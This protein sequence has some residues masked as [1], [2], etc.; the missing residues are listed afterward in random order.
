MIYLTVRYPSGKTA[1]H[2]LKG[3]NI[4]IGRRE[5]VHIRLEDNNV[6]PYHAHI[7]FENDVY[8]CEDGYQGQPSKNG[9]WVNGT[10]VLDIVPLEKGDTI[11]IGACHIIIT[12]VGRIAPATQETSL[13]GKGPPSAQDGY[14]A[15]LLRQLEKKIRYE[16]VK[17]WVS[18]L[19]LVVLTCGAIF[20]VCM[21]M[22]VAVSVIAV[23]ELPK[24]DPVVLPCTAELNPKGVSYIE[25]PLAGK[26]TKIYRQSG[27][28][29]FPGDPLLEISGRSETRK[30][31]SDMKGCIE[32]YQDYPLHLGK[33]VEAGTP[34]CRIV[35]AGQMRL[36]VSL[37]AADLIWERGEIIKGISFE[38]FPQ[39]PFEGI[40]EEL[41]FY[42]GDVDVIVDVP[43]PDARIRAGMKAEV[44]YYPKGRN[45][46]AGSEEE[47]CLVLPAA[48]LIA[49]DS[50]N[51]VYI[52][53]NRRCFRKKVDIKERNAQR[54][55]IFGG[56]EIHPGDL[57]IL[58]PPEDLQ[59]GQRVRLKN[60]GG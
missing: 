3:S 8:W 55:V 57:I 12:D 32:M 34:L 38:D 42:E 51:Q 22:P 31:L 41:A 6:S 24:C 54:I 33:V 7:F 39:L 9:T 47:T 59:D 26:I 19:L 20:L 1:Y 52:V 25:A 36:T 15:N 23:S 27:D 30:V 21:K 13:M 37:R 28:A 60:R 46:F 58:S 11:L 43:N 4:I 5:D 2:T 10:K 35:D 16:N 44:T 45:T 40:V 14:G 53:Q 48:C 18:V 29:T 56:R 17:I 50:G 49:E